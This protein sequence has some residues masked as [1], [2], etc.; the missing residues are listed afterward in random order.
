[1]STLTEPTS[2]VPVPPPLRTT[3]TRSLLSGDVAVSLPLRHSGHPYTLTVAWNRHDRPGAI[4]VIVLP[5]PALT[6]GA[7]DHNAYLRIVH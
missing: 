1:M 6:S 7:Y 4:A 5:I 3:V 2:S